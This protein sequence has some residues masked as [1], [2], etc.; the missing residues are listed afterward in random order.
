[1]P[2]IKVSMGAPPLAVD[3]ALTPSERRRLLD[4]A[5]LLPTQGGRSRDRHR[6]RDAAERP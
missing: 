5:D 6:Y 4:A 2:K 1:M 3:R